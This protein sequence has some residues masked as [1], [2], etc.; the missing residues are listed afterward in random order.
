VAS[1][2]ETHVDVE[3]TEDRLFP[4]MRVVVGDSINN[5]TG[6]FPADFQPG[7]STTVG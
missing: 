2:T 4:E 3:K 5:N 1:R 7:R 6:Q